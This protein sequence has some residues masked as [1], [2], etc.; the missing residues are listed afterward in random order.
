MR[1]LTI[2]TYNIDNKI[3]DRST[4]VESVS[5]PLCISRSLISLLPNDLIIRFSENSEQLEALLS[6]ALDPDAHGV[7]MEVID[8]EERV[9]I[10]VI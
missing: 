10:S 1:K 6:A 5:F 2:E 8:Q 3:V 7:I 4:V 9:V